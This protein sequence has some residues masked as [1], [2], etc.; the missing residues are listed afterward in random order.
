MNIV[1]IEDEALVAEDLERSLRKLIGANINVIH[2]RSVK[3]GITHFKNAN[4]PNLIFSDIQLGDGLSFEIFVTAPV[5]APII[6]CTAYDE[7]A[8]DAFKANGID[9][10]LKPFTIETLENAIE[11]YYNLKRQLSSDQALNTTP[12]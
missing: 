8:L 2:L 12:W 4:A 6:F 11:K 5:T 9:Y 1:I 10:I 3:E 7:Y